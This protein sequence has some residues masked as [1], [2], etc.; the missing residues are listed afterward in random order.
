MKNC[1]LLL[2]LLCCTIFYVLELGDNTFIDLV[3]PTTVKH[4][5]PQNEE[6]P[7]LVYRRLLCFYIRWYQ[8]VCLEVDNSIKIICLW[9]PV[10]FF[11]ESMTVLYIL[12]K[13][14][15]RK[16]FYWPTKLNSPTVLKSLEKI[17]TVCQANLVCFQ[18]CQIYI[19]L[20]IYTPLFYS[21]FLNSDSKHTLWEL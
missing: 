2:Q 17:E 15:F 10:S 16:F 8:R 20:A 6:C 19:C 13:T 12:Y 18:K 1:I 21:K 9:I 4:V 5:I 11:S 14:Y 3:V 7:W